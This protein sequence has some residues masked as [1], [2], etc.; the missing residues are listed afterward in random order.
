M[1]YES[2][3]VSLN[4]SPTTLI[5]GENGAGKSTILD[6]LTFSLFGKSVKMPIDKWRESRPCLAIKH[7]LS[8]GHRIS[9]HD[10]CTVRD[11]AGLSVDLKN[12]IVGKCLRYSLPA[13]TILTF[14]MIEC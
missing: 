8:A 13:Q 6:A 4:N 9:E 3:E 5:V 11:S 12:A 1:S 2:T 7:S 14:G 10:L